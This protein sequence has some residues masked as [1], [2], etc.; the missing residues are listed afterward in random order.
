MKKI[1]FIL[2][3]CFLLSTY[4]CDDSQYLFRENT[5][6]ENETWFVNNQIPFRFTVTDTQEIYK[7]GFN[8]RYTNDYP[9]QNIYVFLH[10]VF[11]NGMRTHDTIDIDLFSL[12]GK[13]LGKGKKTI[14]LQKY[15]S[16]VQFPVAGQYTMSLEQA[17]RIDS[18]PG[19][20]SMGL[21][22][23]QQKKQ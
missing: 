4:S 15:F 20:V 10:T 7:I 1:I 23:A 3:T 2:G 5:S 19:M 8:I 6:I 21:Y 17:M 12:E 18:L 9:M 14:E 11:P 22:I 16:R 13:P